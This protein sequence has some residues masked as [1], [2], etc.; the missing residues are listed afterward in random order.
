MAVTRKSKYQTSMEIMRN[1][2]DGK[3]SLSDILEDT[4]Y[5]RKVVKDTIGQLRK[6]GYLVEIYSEYGTSGEHFEITK[7]GDKTLKKFLEVES[8]LLTHAPEILEN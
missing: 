6:A 8:L 3:G 5:P 7:K 4:G 2:K 1:I